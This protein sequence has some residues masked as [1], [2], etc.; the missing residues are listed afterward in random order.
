MKLIHTKELPVEFVHRTVAINRIISP[1][2]STTKL[3]T[4]NRA[5]LPA[6]Q[7]TEP[8]THEDCEEFYYF[9]KGRGEVVVGN[10]IVPIEPDD[11]VCIA[12]GEEHVVRNTSSADIIFLSIRILL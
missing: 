3:Q 9:L 8:H 11:V 7:T 12:P 10:Q 1:G 5:R 4:F 2:E 6:G